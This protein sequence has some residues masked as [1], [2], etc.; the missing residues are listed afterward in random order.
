[1]LSAYDKL[2]SYIIFTFVYYYVQYLT[3]PPFSYSSKEAICSTWAHTWAVSYC[4]NH[5]GLCGRDSLWCSDHTAS[6]RNSDGSS[7]DSKERSTQKVRVYSVTTLVCTV[8]HQYCYNAVEVHCCIVSFVI[9]VG[10]IGAYHVRKTINNR[11]CFNLKIFS[12]VY[13]TK[14]RNTYINRNYGKKFIIRFSI[15]GE[16]S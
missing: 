14:V 15:K 7:Q 1:M 12:V 5:W 8:R 11:R 2:P 9:I 13:K 3:F 16:V 6:G 4:S 10:I